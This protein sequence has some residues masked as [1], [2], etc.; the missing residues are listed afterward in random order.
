MPVSLKLIGSRIKEARE[1]QHL[2]QPQLAEAANLS[3]SHL[4]D[5]EL[6]RSNFSV[7]IL[8]RI[9]EALQIS[10]DQLLR[11]DTPSVISIYEDEIHG[12][13]A[14]CSPDEIESMKK[15]LLHMK[16]A[17]HNAKRGVTE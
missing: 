1:A 11:A 17:L 15:M 12:I 10:A 14:G 13:L 6:G 3:L 4:S 2:T 8:S 7:A 9:I 16:E 5:I